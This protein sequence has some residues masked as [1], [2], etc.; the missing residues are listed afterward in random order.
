MGVSRVRLSIDHLVLKGIE[1]G[2]RNALVEGLQTELSRVLADLAVRAEWA[3]SH[4]T[5]V[6]RLGRTPLE[7]GASGAR[8]FGRGVARKVI[9]ALRAK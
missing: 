4:R 1:P 9:S 3:R 5:P 7:S 2:D 8:K 6:L